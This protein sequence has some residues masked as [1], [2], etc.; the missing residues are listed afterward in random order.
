MQLNIFFYHLS[1][2][3][4]FSGLSEIGEGNHIFWSPPE[5][6]RSVPLRD[7]SM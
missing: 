3:N 7:E 2:V 6:S 5:F 1:L 4:S